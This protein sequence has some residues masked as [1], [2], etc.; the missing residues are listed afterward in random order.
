MSGAQRK[1]IKTYLYEIKSYI[2]KEAD[3]EQHETTVRVIGIGHSE[4]EATGA[5]L[6][7]FTFKLKTFLLDLEDLAV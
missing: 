6:I 2:T 4:E 5:V 1:D 7:S 3:T